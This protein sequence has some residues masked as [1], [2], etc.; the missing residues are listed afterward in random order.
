MQ[1]GILVSNA[2]L[3]WLQQLVAGLSLRRPGFNAKKI[4]VV[5]VVKK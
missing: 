2:S 5:F 1:K 4:H 3:L